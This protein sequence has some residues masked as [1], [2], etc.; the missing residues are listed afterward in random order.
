MHPCILNARDLHPHVRH[1]GHLSSR[2]DS[3]RAPENNGTG[4]SVKRGG[5]VFEG[6]RVGSGSSPVS[7]LQKAGTSKDQ[8]VNTRGG[9][10]S[11]GAS[12]QVLHGG[13]ALCVN[14]SQRMYVPHKTPECPRNVLRA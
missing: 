13:R 10:R 9:D 1:A 12:S 5:L 4:A 6:V 2:P 8:R 7:P 3:P 11:V 14:L